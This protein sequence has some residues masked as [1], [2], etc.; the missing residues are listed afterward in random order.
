M[1]NLNLVVKFMLAAD[2]L[3]QVK[4][5]ARIKVDGRGGLLLYD[6]Q[7]GSVETIQLGALQSLCLHP[8]RGRRQRCL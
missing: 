2:G 6:A 4:G 7:G 5:A 3:M 8:V 1:D